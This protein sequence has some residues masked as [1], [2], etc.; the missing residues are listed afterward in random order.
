MKQIRKYETYEEYIKHQ[1]SKL[2]EKPKEVAFMNKEIRDRV[3]ARYKDMYDWKGKTVMCLAARLGGEVEAFKKLGAVAVGIDIE[4]GWHNPHVLYGDFHGL[5]FSD[6]C[7]DFVYC[8]AIDHA[9]NIDAFFNEANRI[10][11]K[12]GIMF[13]EVAIQKGGDYEVIDTDNVEELTKEVSKH[14]KS[15]TTTPIGNVWVGVLYK[16]VK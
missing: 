7:F 14:F 4:P 1:S 13:L 3:Y 11:K 15:F 16:I 6:E 2:H 8:N 9:L 12:G 10:L 5:N